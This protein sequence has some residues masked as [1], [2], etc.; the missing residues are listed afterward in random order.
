MQDLRKKWNEA[1]WIPFTKSSWN[2]QKG[3]RRLEWQINTCRKA[4]MVQA[5]LAAINEAVGHVHE[6]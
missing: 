4:V 5:D 1:T 2:E 3:I 6:T